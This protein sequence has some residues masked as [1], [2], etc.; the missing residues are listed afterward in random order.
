MRRMF[1][2]RSSLLNPSPLDKFSRTT[3]PSKISTFNPR[4]R[5]SFSTRRETVVLPA[6]LNPVNQTVKP[7]DKFFSKLVIGKW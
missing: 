6:P 3:S 5:N 7:L 4:A 2:S 1:V